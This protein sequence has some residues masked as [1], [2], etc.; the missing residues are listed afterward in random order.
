MDKDGG[1]G[2]A[3]D[4]DYAHDR[5]DGHVR[6]HGRDRANA[7]ASIQG[8]VFFAELFI[9]TRGIAIAVTGAIFH[10]TANAFD[11]VV[12]AFLRQTNLCFKPQHLLTIFAHL[13]VHDIFAIECFFNAIHE[14]INDQIMIV[15]ITSFDELNI[16][17]FCCNFIRIAVYPFHQNT[18]EKEVRE[19]QNPFV[20][21][22]CRLAQC[23]G[24]QWKCYAGIGDFTP[25]KT[26]TLP[27]HTHN[28]G[29]I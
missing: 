2:H 11:M 7:Q 22:L 10:A 20:P 4:H 19:H 25:S 6:G 24:C 17:M 3:C 5:D 29:N 21:E 12:V 13:A 8:H 26:H 23:G 1:H 27:K 18:G 28:F 14:R 15:Q 16:G 9:A